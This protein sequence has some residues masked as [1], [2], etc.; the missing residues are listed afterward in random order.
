MSNVD[1]TPKSWNHLQ[2]WIFEASE[3][4]LGLNGVEVG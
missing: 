1:P 4:I 2:D 3:A